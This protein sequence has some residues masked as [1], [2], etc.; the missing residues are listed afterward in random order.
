MEVKYETEMNVDLG[1]LADEWNLKGFNVCHVHGSFDFY[2][3]IFTN[4]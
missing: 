1:H 2:S 3:P 4:V